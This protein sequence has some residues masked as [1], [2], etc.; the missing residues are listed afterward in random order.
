[1]RLKGRER[2]HKRVRK[3]IIGTL[4]VPLDDSPEEEFNSSY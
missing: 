4:R 1:M 2:R 3:K